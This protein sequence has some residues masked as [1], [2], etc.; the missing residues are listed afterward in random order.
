MLLTLIIAAVLF[1]NQ[2]GQYFDEHA[3]IAVFRVPDNYCTGNRAES[4]ADVN[5]VE[6]TAWWYFESCCKDP[7]T[8]LYDSVYQSFPNWEMANKKLQA[9]LKLE[10]QRAKVSDKWWDDS[11]PEIRLLNRLGEEYL[12]IKGDVRAVY[13][14]AREMKRDILYARS[15]DYPGRVMPVYFAGR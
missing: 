9:Y 15:P 7:K 8:G 6:I 12:S 1:S 5:E 4:E 2:P 3:T 10:R 13:S 11:S 14:S